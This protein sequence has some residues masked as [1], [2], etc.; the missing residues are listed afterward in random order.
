MKT[1]HHHNDIGNNAIDELIGK[2]A[3]HDPTS[4]TP[5]D[6]VRERVRSRHVLGSRECRKKLLS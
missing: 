1:R 6:S 5:D 3:K 4:I 2:P